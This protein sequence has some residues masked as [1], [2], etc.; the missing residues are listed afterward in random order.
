[1]NHWWRGA[2]DDRVVAA[3]AVRVAVLHRVVRLVEQRALL[4]QQLDDQRV[5]LEDLLA[6]EQRARTVSS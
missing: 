6:R 2:E 4:H 1:M 3:P 5:G